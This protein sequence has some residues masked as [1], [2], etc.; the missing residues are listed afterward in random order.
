M[1]M[2]SKMLTQHNHHHHL[3]TYIMRYEFHDRGDKRSV[4]LALFCG[5]ALLGATIV[6]IA[7]TLRFAA[8]RA[9]R[10]C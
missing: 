4:V 1:Y 8:S 6:V 3:A 7:S 10:R 5:R 9:S 2:N